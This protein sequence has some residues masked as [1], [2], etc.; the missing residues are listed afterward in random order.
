M[1]LDTYH[2]LILILIYKILLVGGFCV[3]YG[4]SSSQ[5]SRRIMLACIVV[6]PFLS[7]CVSIINAIF[8]IQHKVLYFAK[9]RALETMNLAD[10]RAH[11]FNAL[12]GVFFALS[13][14]SY[15]R[16]S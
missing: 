4:L 2:K 8:G 11:H 9:G 5:P 14:F 6:V 12:I 15:R 10:N 13:L 1:S 7:G 3:V 16:N